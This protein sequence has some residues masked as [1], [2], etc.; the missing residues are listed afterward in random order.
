MTSAWLA[1][2]QHPLD[3]AIAALGMTAQTAVLLRLYNNHL[4]R[5]WPSI[6]SMMW[7]AIT[8]NLYLIPMMHSHSHYRQYF[9]IYWA[10]SGL[11]ALLRFWLIADVAKSFTGLDFI[12]LRFHMWSTL[13][14]FVTALGI[15]CWSFR[16]Y[17]RLAQG[18]HS[19]VLYSGSFSLGWMAFLAVL[20]GI[21][22]IPRIAWDSVGSQVTQGF[23]L[24]LAG[25]GLGSLLLTYSH[26]FHTLSYLI[27]S[28]CSI[29]CYVLWSSAFQSTN[30]RSK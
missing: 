26:T 25:S 8:S 6:A 27:D 1:L 18:V 15:C 9:Y 24:Q 29:G 5:Q 22:H 11:A 17:P 30:E 21:Y 16:D 10:T 28:S 3:Y 7:L 14:A 13:I 12:P 2:A 19:V 20:L 4:T 23:I